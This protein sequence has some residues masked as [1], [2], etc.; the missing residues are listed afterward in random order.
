M[1]RF[2]DTKEIACKP[3]KNYDKRTE[4]YDKRTENYDKRTENYDTSTAKIVDVKKRKHTGWRDHH[5]AKAPCTLPLRLQKPIALQRADNKN[6]KTKDYENEQRIMIN[7]QR[8][9][10]N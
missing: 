6:T 10:I 5:G 2:L 1:W 7:E 4:N 3:T 9:T 8:I